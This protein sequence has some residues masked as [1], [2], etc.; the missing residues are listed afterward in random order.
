MKK[1]I[2]KNRKTSSAIKVRIPKIL[3]LSAFIMAAIFITACNNNENENGDVQ[4]IRQQIS[5]YNQQIVEMSQKVS[6]LERK[7]EE[8]G[9][10]P[11]NRIRTPVTV[12]EITP[13]PFDHYFKVNASVEAIQE[14]MISPETN[15]QIREI[16][17]RKGERVRSGQILARLNTSVIENNI[18][19]VKTS[20]QLAQTVYNRQKSLWEQEIGSEIQYLEA[21]NNY[22]S[23]QSRLKSLESQLDMAI[24]RAPF[25]G[26]VDEIFAKEGELAM[27]GSMVMQLLNLRDLY[28]NADVSESFLPLIDPSEKVILRFSAFPDYEEEV[29]V[30]R[31]GNVINPE[32]RTFRLQL[33]IRNPEEKFKPNMVATMSIRSYTAADALVVPSILIKQD[34]QGHYVYVADEN[35]DGDLVAQKVYIERGLSGEGRTMIKSGIKE[36]DLVINQGHNR[37]NDGALVAISEERS[38]ARNN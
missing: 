22:E 3:S 7:L 1:L 19:E 12:T 2:V 10:V 25:D 32:N 30:H 34:T 5:E 8:L 29:P 14:A 20:L 33:R 21:R 4:S 26:V 27:P 37:V 18:A 23:L 9:E 11:Q 6:E 13:Q 16:P 36:G 38:L 35:D 28:V 24:M 31:M 17:V 15:G